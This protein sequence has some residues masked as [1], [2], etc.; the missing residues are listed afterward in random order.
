MAWMVVLA[1]LLS[2]S[3]ALAEDKRSGTILAIDPGGQSL[4]LEEISAG[5]APGRNQI[6]TQPISL[7]SDTVITLVSR[8]EE[9]DSTSWPGGFT[10]TRLAPADL[11]TGDYAT[12]ETA[13]RAGKLVARSVTVIR[14]V[15]PER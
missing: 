13:H 11:R 1:G 3:P 10:E 7:T 12:V 9:A 4:T 2:T 6:L 8:A 15:S 5:I 14:P